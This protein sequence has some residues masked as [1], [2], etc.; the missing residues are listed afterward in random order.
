MSPLS[1]SHDTTIHRPRL[2]R[3]LQAKPSQ[4]LAPVEPG[5]GTQ[6]IAPQAKGTYTA[7]R[8]RWRGEAKDGGEREEAGE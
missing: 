1:S 5:G 6:G 8:Q 3:N 4:S 7:N 2:R